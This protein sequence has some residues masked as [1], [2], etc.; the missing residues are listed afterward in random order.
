MEAQTSRMNRL[1]LEHIVAK[2]VPLASAREIKVLQI[3]EGN[4]LRGFFDWMIHECYKKEVFDGGIVVTQPRPSGKKKLDELRHQDGLYTLM[5]RGLQNGKKVDTNEIISVFTETI[6]PYS[7][8][9]QFMALAENP[10]LEFVVSNTTE[11]GLTYQKSDLVEGVP[12]ESFPGKL[13]AFLYRRYQHFHGD[14]KKGLVLLP[15]ELLAR[16]GDTLKACVLQHSQDWQL[17]DPFVEW[18]NEH[19]LF[20]NSLVD[21]IVP[22]YPAAEAET[23]FSEWGY[24]DAM[25]NVTEPYHL[26]VIEGDLA[27]DE[28][29]PLQKAGLNVHWV[30]DLTPYQVRKVRI[31]NGL[32]TLM[33]PMAMLHGLKEVRETVEHPDLGSF[34]QEAMEHEIVPSLN[35]DVKTTMEYAGTVIERFKNP[36]ICHRLADISLNSLSKFKVRLL[37]TLLEYVSKQGQL[38]DR[39]VKSFAYLL[40][41]YRVRR[42]ESEYVGHRFTGEAYQVKDDAESLAFFS[43]QWGSLEA[44]KVSLEELVE[45]LLSNS[46]LWGEDLSHCPGLVQR[47]CMELREMEDV[48]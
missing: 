25:L 19:N 1:G 16:N 24:Q 10:T 47:L 15:C 8:W 37:P 7:E 33:T 30:E 27:L 29:L 45:N 5:T 34:I 26:W 6:D 9:S 44:N 46:A 36:F 18:L 39:I 14:T 4:F 28:R 41:F 32:H 12:I 40:R 2:D 42:V 11:A 17:P 13:T 3:G 38:P 48:Q 20:L 23:W 21:R 35:Y 31:L 43:E 22:G